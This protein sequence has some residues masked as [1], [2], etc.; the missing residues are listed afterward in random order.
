MPCSHRAHQ[1]GC[2][3]DVPTL[4]ILVTCSS[5]PQ[6]FLSSD[7]HN[8]L[9]MDPK[10]S[11]LSSEPVP[12][13]ALRMP[14]DLSSKHPDLSTGVLLQWSLGQRLPPFSPHL[15]HLH[16]ASLSSLAQPPLNSRSLSQAHVPSSLSRSIASSGFT[17]M[18]V[19]RP[20]LSLYL[21]RHLTIL[22]AYQ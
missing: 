3:V 22:L 15:I 14:L 13:T 19:S 18:S 1:R 10:A 8:G 7:C 6:A 20:P 5:P 4:P 2:S 17:V 16:E 12:P 9:L 11:L 21:P